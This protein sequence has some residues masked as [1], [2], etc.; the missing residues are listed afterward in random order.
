MHTDTCLSWGRVA[1]SFLFLEFTIL[2]SYQLT[3]Q[4]HSL[5]ALWAQLWGLLPLTLGMKFFNHVAKLADVEGGHYPVRVLTYPWVHFLCSVLLS[6][7]IVYVVDLELP[8]AWSCALT[9]EPG[10]DLHLTDSRTVNLVLSTPAVKGLTIQDFD[11][12]RQ[13][14]KNDVQYSSTWLK[15]NPQV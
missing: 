11:L 14:D 7:N 12:A 8:S 5:P 4:V 13:I 3:R 9:C 1:A 2:D 6:R 10:Q 15:E